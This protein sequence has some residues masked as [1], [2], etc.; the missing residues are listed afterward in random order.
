MTRWQHPRADVTATVDHDHQHRRRRRQVPSSSGNRLA[1]TTDHT[2]PDH[3]LTH[4]PV[5]RIRPTILRTQTPDVATERRDRPRPATRSAI[6]VAGID[7][8]SDNNGRT[9]GSNAVTRTTLSCLYFGGSD[10]ATALSH[11]LPRDPQSRRLSVCG[12]PSVANRRI[13]AQSSTAIT[14][15]RVAH[16][17]PSLMAYFSTVVDTMTGRENLVFFEAMG[18]LSRRAPGARSDLRRPSNIYSHRGSARS[19]DLERR[20][21]Y[22][23]G[24]IGGRPLQSHSGTS[25]ACTPSARSSAAISSW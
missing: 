25:S 15:L 13:N 7:G 16:F 12:T 19:R 8:Y 3:P 9:R 2:A 4:Q 5:S 10:D 11:R 23:N 20:F 18:W 1:G 22:S 6:I 24:C 21:D 17:R 14:P